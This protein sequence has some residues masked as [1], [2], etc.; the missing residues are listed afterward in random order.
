MY[1]RIKIIIQLMQ[2]Q[3]ITKSGPRFRGTA[4]VLL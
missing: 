3:Y 1:F 2:N 4:V